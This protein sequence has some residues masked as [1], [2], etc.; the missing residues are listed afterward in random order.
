MGVG[1][2]GLPPPQP[3][4]AAQ[5]RGQEFRRAFLIPLPCEGENKNFGVHF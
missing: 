4:P 2:V 1:E 5:G 3:S